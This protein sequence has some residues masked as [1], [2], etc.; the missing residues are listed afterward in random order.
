MAVTVSVKSASLFAGGVIVR[1]STCSAVT[2]HWPFPRSIPAL[3][4]A[5][6]G[7]PEITIDTAIV[8]A[9]WR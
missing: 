3:S 1:P 4:S 8:S 6:S 2:L 9:N 7:T 5:P